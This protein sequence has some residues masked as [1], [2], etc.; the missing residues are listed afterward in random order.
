MLSI[1]F[2]DIERIRYPK[3]HTSPPFSQSFAAQLRESWQLSSPISGHRRRFQVTG[4]VI[5]SKNPVPSP[6]PSTLNLNLNLTLTLTL[7]P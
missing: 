4:M 3:V 6:S 7:F 1:E 5:P 2:A